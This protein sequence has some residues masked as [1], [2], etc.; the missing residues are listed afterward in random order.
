MERK[1]VAPLTISLPRKTKKDKVCSINLN[2]YR[3]WHYI[4]S[5]QIKR[6]Y[7][8]QVASQLDGLLFDKPIKLHFVLYKSSNRKI[9]RANM[10]SVHEK[11]FCDALTECG[12]IVDDNDEYILETKYTTGGVD[13]DNP[14][15]EILIST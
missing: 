15:V 12:C 5:N 6:E 11:F 3:N 4:V 9:D 2:S 1:I 14:R 13:K 8:N 10:L 7:K